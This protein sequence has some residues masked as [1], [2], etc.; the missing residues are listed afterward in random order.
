MDLSWSR[1]P[2]YSCTIKAFSG[3][4][5][6]LDEQNVLGRDESMAEV[7]MFR[8]FWGCIL[9][10]VLQEIVALRGQ[11]LSRVRTIAF[12]IQG[13]LM[14]RSCAGLSVC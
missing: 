8:Q 11:N 14:C 10:S 2:R 12:W 4:Q 1:I 7:K 9:Q 3:N 5:R 13:A 6:V